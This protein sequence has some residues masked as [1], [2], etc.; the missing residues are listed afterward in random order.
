MTIEQ[1]GLH[2][3]GRDRERGNRKGVKLLMHQDRDQQH[4]A[5]ERCERQC[6]SKVVNQSLEMPFHLH[7]FRHWVAGFSWSPTEPRCLAEFLWRGFHQDVF[8]VTRRFD[9]AS[10]SDVG[11]H[12]KTTRKNT[13]PR[14]AAYIARLR[15]RGDRMKRRELIAR[16]GGVVAWPL[17]NRGLIH[18]LAAQAA[19]INFAASM[20]P[21]PHR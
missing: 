11:I 12:N 8:S 21:A 18:S 15:R 4:D 14:C 6:N 5:S 16:L 9:T 13:R 2:S 3:R 1:A 10:A 19:A 7:E 17:A 20:L